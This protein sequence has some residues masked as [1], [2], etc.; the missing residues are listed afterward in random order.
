MKQTTK[1]KETEIGMIPE[2]WQI[3]PL[4]ELLELLKDGS[5][6]PPKRHS[7]GIKFIAGASDL[8]Y[9]HIDFSNCTYIN[10]ED[11]HKI[12][13][14]YQ[15][16]ANDI[17]LT[18]VGTVGNVAIVKKEDLPFSMQRSIAIMRCGKELHYE[19]LFYWLTSNQFK[20]L[21]SSRIN[22]TAQPGIYL[23]ELSKLL[24]PV[25]KLDEQI[26][27][28]KIL[29][30]VDSKIEINQ[31]IN[32]T[33][34]L[35]GQTLFNQW[36]L[37]FEF[38]NVRGKPYKSSGGEM[39]D[40]ELGEI[41]KGWSVAN[42]TSIAQIIDCL[43]SKK[44]DS[45]TGGKI[46]LQVYNISKHGT[47][48]LEDKY[49]VSDE[50]YIY[51]TRNVEVRKGDCIITNAGLVGAIAQI[52]EDFI[53]GV[54]RNITVIRPEKIPP[55]YLLR[56]LNSSYGIEQI[57]KNTDQGTIF[58]SLNVKGIKKINIIVPSKEIITLFETIS[59]SLRAKVENNVLETNR[60]KSL[61]DLLLPKLMSGQIRVK[62]NG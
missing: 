3:K 58:N 43:H 41:P 51:W 13:K 38:P 29:S 55:T 56:Y 37:N 19:F 34:E 33:L 17:L 39:I 8:T 11:Y 20:L 35:I 16:N 23:G 48:N 25:P 42:L 6:N 7:S 40:S 32:N 9:R 50:D 24:T 44:P 30:A 60:L 28:A 62:W 46:L 18:I 4:G 10:E 27:I 47:L 57:T 45:V 2:D 1:F 12:H 52:P 26:K 53:S 61:R 5:H 59:R 31:E 54:G 21:I 49:L 22:T 36:F 15:I 14:Y